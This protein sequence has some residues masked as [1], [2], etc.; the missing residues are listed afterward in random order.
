MLAAT[1]TLLPVFRKEEGIGAKEEVETGRILLL[2]V[3]FFQIASLTM[4]VTKDLHL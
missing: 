2:R 1:A 3:P 4:S